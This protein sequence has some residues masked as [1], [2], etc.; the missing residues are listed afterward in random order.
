[1]QEPIRL[2]IVG[3]GLVG[4]RHANAIRHVDGVELTAVVDPSESARAFANHTGA[5]WLEDL[6]ELLDADAPDGVI[7]ATPT[8]LH[9]DQGLACIKRGWPVLIE[10]PLAA[11]VEGAERIAHA[12]RAMNAAVLVGHH[13]RHNPIVQKAK[14]LIE[15]GEIG[16]IRTAHA[17]CW[18]HK[19]DSYFDDAP[20]RKEA[21]AGPISVNL[22]HDV[23]LIRHLCG[24][25]VSVQAQAV[26]SSRGFANE[27]AAAAVLRFESGAVGTITV[28]DSVASPW[29]W[30]L[31]AREYPIYPATGESCYMLGGSVGALSIPDLRLWRHDREPD[32]W[33]PISAAHHPVA[34]SDPLAN[35]IVQFAEVIS[36]GATPLVSADEGL[37]TMRVV[38][39]IQT[40]AA[41][42]ET[43]A[44][45]QQ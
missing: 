15:S 12:A 36:H 19:P 13:R 1:M 41:T 31:T 24:E 10:K 26:P 14:S 29:S 3:L 33:S 7:L 17:T 22:V 11:T 21:G 37:A 8:P 2:A 39:A 45:S 6:G 38:G 4:Q 20:W 43:V 42:G 30:E 28:A 25:V 16:P 27:E 34:A 9:V 5:R 44:I 32:W 23:D 18:F 40:A 35:Q